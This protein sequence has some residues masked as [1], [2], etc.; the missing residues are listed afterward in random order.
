MASPA[1]QLI[2][3]S[4]GNGWTVIE[5]LKQLPNQTGGCFS[6][7]YVAVDER[8]NKAFLKDLDYSRAMRSDDP[9]RELEAFTKSYNLERDLLNRCQ[10]MDR[11]VRGLTDGSVTV[12]TSSGGEVVQYL[13]LE[14]ADS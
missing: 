3:L 4:L 8:G 11:V 9:A 14:L 13:I 5:R 1:S 2:G 7:G 10:G 6:E 12:A